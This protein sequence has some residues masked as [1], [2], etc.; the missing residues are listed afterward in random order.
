M[1]L[2]HLILFLAVVVAGCSSRHP[3]ETL[4]IDCVECKAF[5]SESGNI[6]SPNKQLQAID[7][8]MWR[9]PDS[10]LMVLV[11]FAASPQA[12]SLDAFEE[13]Y[14]QMLLSELL[15]KNDF[16][17]NNREKLLKAVRCFDSIVGTD[18]TDARKA[19]T[20]GVSLR[21]RNA[22]LD[23][24]AH[25]INGVGFYERDNLVEAC[26][27]Y[28]K[29]LEVMEG[30]FGEEDLVKNKAKF[31]AY[32]YNRL[33]DM[34]S[35]Q[36]M[37]EAAITCYENALAYC[38][39]EPTSPTG[40]SNTL[41]RLGLQY[42]KLKDTE[43][44]KAYYSQ[45]LEE[46]SDSDNLSYRD[47]AASKALCDYKADSNAEQ[48]LETLRHILSQAEDEN[49]RLTRYLSIG[50]IFSH[51]E[52]FDSAVAYLES[53]F[54][55]TRDEV[56][57]IQAA[58]HLHNIYESLGNEA[59]S[60]EC[61]R[62]LANHKV[63]ASE[64]KVLVSQLDNLFQDYL[65]QKQGK[66]SEAEHA[67]H[68]RKI[69]GI[70]VPIAVL[71]AMAIIIVAKLRSR[72]LLK[73]QQKEAEQAHEE[74]RRL[75]TETQQRLEETERKHRQKEEEMVK[76]HED[77]LRIQRDQSE[78]EME[79]TR[80]RHKAELEAERLAY[81]KEQDAL[82]QSLR[83]H[84]D[85]VMA[86]EKSS[87]LQQDKAERWR[88]EFLKEP[89]CRRINELLHGKRITTRDTS[90]K[91]DD[92]TLKEEDFKQLREAVERHFEGFDAFLLSCCPSLKR[93]DLALCHLHLMG[94]G[95]GEIAALK[96]RT[97]S[98]IKKQDES[99]K[100]KLS[101]EESVSEYVLR[102]AKGLYVPQDVPQ[103][104]LKT[105]LTIMSNNPN[106]TREEM[107]NQLDVS[108]KTIG[109]YLKKL[110]GKV[111]YVGSGYSGH[112]EVIE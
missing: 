18:E 106:I 86:S 104:P 13:H 52:M 59:R 111:R 65:K 109:R 16:G 48:S 81:E 92:I 30:H 31:M 29:A 38:R 36:F 94:L 10:A 25:Y 43:K 47:M 71:L 66:L 96:S 49:E 61:I 77:E 37:M 102:I 58:E 63:S 95:E 68:V 4:V 56:S 100:E 12:D 53:V 69:V 108:S 67:K 93:G 98:G 50:V 60:N 78:K 17:Q 73:Q 23:A 72:K 51:E 24:R 33:G 80:Q 22:F 35:G 82:R 75:Q 107:A 1:K 62:F 83:Q 44:M 42:E 88:Q 5:P 15:Y 21:E 34:F 28:L 26:A 11:D 2:K 74:L 79:Q 90:F 64:N 45:A 6:A 103:D 27:E 105:I 99:I 7:S 91:H 9:Q 101:L 32:T 89:I 41:I 85:Q 40:V 87:G 97:Y 84:E 19:D 39:I 57:Q 55:N 54:E 3:V 110:D 20:R 70:I 8:L 76:R 112:W 14:C 46:M